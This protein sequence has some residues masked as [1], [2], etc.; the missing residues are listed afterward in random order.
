MEDLNIVWVI[1]IAIIIGAW[2]WARRIRK[3]ISVM[4]NHIHEIMSTVIFMRTETHNDVIYAYNAMNDEFVCQG[5]SMEE[6]NNRF[7]I[8]Y[9]N[10]KGII[11]KPDEETTT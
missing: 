7:G 8:R 2:L 5:T 1:A 10:C 4:E 9:P 3:D 6:L 11:V